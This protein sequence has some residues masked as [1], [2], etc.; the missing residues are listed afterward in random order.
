MKR[1]S[2]IELAIRRQQAM[3]LTVEQVRAVLDYD[4]ETGRFTRKANRPLALVGTD[5]T[6]LK[7]DG[8]YVVSVCGEREIRAHRLAWFITYGEWPAG[9]VDHINGDPRDNRIAN[10]RVAS[11]SQNAAN[12]RTQ[13]RKQLKGITFNKKVGKWQ[14]AA[15]KKYLGVFDSPEAAHAAYVTAAQ[16]LWGE[17]AS[18]GRMV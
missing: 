1:P 10:L 15:R 2:T 14:A 11:R 18:D 9:E 6:R 17:Y 3:T 7:R 12:Q 8:Y 4:P 5:P 13:A 16:S